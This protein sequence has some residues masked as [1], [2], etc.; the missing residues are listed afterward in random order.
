MRG[1]QRPDTMNLVRAQRLRLGLSQEDLAALAGVS[2]RSI[3]LVESR[4]DRRVRPSTARLLAD[5]LQVPADQR[6]DFIGSLV[7][8]ALGRAPGRKPDT[9]QASLPAV[10]PAALPEFTGRRDQLDQLDQLLRRGQQGSTGPAIGVIYGPAG[11]GKTALAVH[12]GH[13]VADQFPDGQLYL[14]LHGFDSA[15]ECVSVTEAVRA[16]LDALD[17]PRSRM[18]TGLDA[19]VGLYRSL[20]AGRRMLLVLDD[21]RDAGQ[22]WP[23]LP[24]LPGSVILVTSRNLPDSLIAVEGAQPITVEVFRPAGSAD[25]VP[26]VGSRWVPAQLPRPLATFVGRGQELE[27]LTALVRVADGDDTH[28]PAAGVAVISG[29]AGVGKST[30]ATHWAHRVAR[31]FPDGQLY[32]DLR[33]FDVGGPADPAEAL[34]DLLEGLGVPPA[35][36]PAAEAA[37]CAIY[38]SLLAGRRVLVV[39]D[40][41]RDAEQVRPLLPGAPECAV[42]VTSRSTLTGLVVTDGAVLVRLGLLDARDAAQLLLRR[43]DPAHVTVRPAALD[44]TVAACAGLPLALAIVAARAA[45]R[46]G[47]SLATIAGELATEGLDVL[48]AG[49]PATNL[50]AVLSWSYLALSPAAAELFRLL[51]LFPGPDIAPAAA[52]SLAGRP[53]AD[54]RQLLGE[55]T[56]VNLVDEHRCGR[57]SLHDLV[58]TYAAEQMQA[59]G[60]EEDRQT[61]MTRLLSHYLHTADRASHLRYSYRSPISLPDRPPG[62]VV[63]ALS[64]RQHAEDWFAAE[65]AAMVSLVRWA[66]QPLFESYAWRLAWTLWD[67]VSDKPGH[68]RGWVAVQRVVLAAGATSTDPVA[69]AHMHRGLGLAACQSGELDEADRHLRVAIDH[70]AAAGDHRG[71][72]NTHRNLARVLAWQEQPHAALENAVQA[73]RLADSCGDRHTQAAALNQ[74]GWYHAHIGNYRQ[75]LIA[76]RRALGLHRRT[77]NRD[78]QAAAWDSLGF[79][80]HGLSDYGQAISCYQTAIALLE[81]LAD[82]YE[83][84]ATLD[85]LGDTYHAAGR[86]HDARDA[87]RCAADRLRQLNHPQA[88]DTLAKLAETRGAQS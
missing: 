28:A 74:A 72:A 81:E 65:S 41:A 7:H 73:V 56:G 36:I 64:D 10:L 88:V 86:L 62:V 53:V 22:V 50:R 58:R 38:R 57:F 39:L 49:G 85:R 83:H 40:N 26:T 29:P 32:A 21:A 63:E 77:G 24:D 71:Q 5:A 67:Y 44:A 30:L 27:R 3:Q 48:D 16:L 87:W 37:Q 82:D 76:C 20:V 42:V 43:L 13:R 79:I 52:A 31:L 19:Q 61:A 33:G 17:A 55:L 35:E 15:A 69:L 12:W 9:G 59:A 25:A 4:P 1:R 80:Y 6:E 18:A 8:D 51:T 45:E 70:Y 23:L 68:W 11:A 78:G 60:S 2:V 66:A 47:D 46:S 75:A 34:R 54:V 84:A 14:N